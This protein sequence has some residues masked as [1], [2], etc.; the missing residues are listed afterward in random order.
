[1]ASAPE[2]VRAQERDSDDSMPCSKRR[3]VD[4][5]NCCFKDEWREK[6][7]FVLP[8]GSSKPVCPIFQKLGINQKQQC[9]APLRNEA[10]IFWVKLFTE[11]WA[12]GMQNNQIVAETLFEGK[13]KDELCEKIKQI[14][15]SASTA[16]RKSEILADDVLAQ[17]DIAIQCATLNSLG[18]DFFN[19]REK[20]VI[21]AF[22]CT[23]LFIL[24]WGF[25]FL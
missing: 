18:W 13:Q 9:E 23:F 24:F 10:Q 11:V 16:T 7:I 22:V 1:M 8:A 14:L 6:Y 25:C 3:K 2:R 21:Q 19:V 12:E 20:K 4:V 15:M 5:E 17:L